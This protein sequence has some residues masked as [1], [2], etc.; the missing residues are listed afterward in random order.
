MKTNKT[1]SGNIGTNPI[2]DQIIMINNKV[3]IAEEI[4]ERI[5]KID[6]F[7]NI[8]KATFLNKQEIQKNEIRSSYFAK[9]RTPK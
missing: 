1:K 6:N 7:F 9:A 5:V 4:N 2:T 8:M 3:N